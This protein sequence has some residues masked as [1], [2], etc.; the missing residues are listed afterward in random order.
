[1]YPGCV[2]VLLHVLLH[3]L[4]WLCLLSCCYMIFSSAL[5]HESIVF[6]VRCSSGLME[7]SR[8]QQ[9]AFGQPLEV[10]RWISQA[11]R[12]GCVYVCLTLS[13]CIWLFCPH[14]SILLLLSSYV[15]RV[16]QYA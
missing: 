16:L 9:E 12:F 6:K 1:V 2:S 5:L 4:Q 3:A 13:M 11:R 10:L 7:E 8:T 14:C 15:E